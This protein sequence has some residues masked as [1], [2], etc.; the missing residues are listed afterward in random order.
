MFHFP[1][2]FSWFN[3]QAAENINSLWH[4]STKWNIFI[5]KSNIQLNTTSIVLHFSQFWS[6]LRSSHKYEFLNYF[7]TFFILQFFLWF[8][9]HKFQFSS[10]DEN[11]SLSSFMNFTLFLK[12]FMHA[13]KCT[14]FTSL[15]FAALCSSANENLFAEGLFTIF[16]FLSFPSFDNIFNT[17]FI[18]NE[19]FFYYAL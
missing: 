15:L 8:I 18:R 14:F 1:E 4:L 9:N 12:E 2:F 10:A 17:V 13:I 7:Q 16:F 11:L 19:T 6:L 5:S 3:W